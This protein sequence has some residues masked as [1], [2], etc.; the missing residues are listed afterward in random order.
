MVS[1]WFLA[2]F[3]VAFAPLTGVAAL[4]EKPS[5]LPLLLDATAEELTLGLEAGNFTSVDLVNVSSDP[6]PTSI[7]VSFGRAM[8]S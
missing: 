3:F 2:K 7:R 4:Y 8:S 6:F 1:A 5:Q